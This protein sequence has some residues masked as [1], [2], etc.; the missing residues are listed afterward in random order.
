MYTKSFFKVLVGLTTLFG[1]GMQ[2]FGQ[3][4][5]ELFQ[6]A[7]DLRH[8]GDYARA[9][10]Y[11]QRVKGCGDASYRKDCEKW[12]G[13]CRKRLPSLD[14]SESVVRIPYQGGDRKVGVSANGK[15]GIDGSVM[16]WCAT[17]VGDRE[18]VLQCREPN[19]S[20]REKITTLTVKSGSLFRTL[21]VIQD[22]RPE[23]L[24]VSSQ[25]LSFPADGATEE[26]SVETNARWEVSSVP[27][28]CK[29]ER[30]ST[31]IRIVVEANDRIVERDDRIVIVSPS[32]NVTIKI[33]QGAG[34]EHLTLSH[35]DLQLPPEGD[36][37]YIRVYTDADN[38]YVGD[39]PDWCD[40]RRVGTDS[41]RVHV[42]KNVPNGESRM[43]SIKIRT[44]RQTAGVYLVQAPRMPQDLI[45]PEGKVLGGRNVSFGVTAGYVFPMVGASAGGEYVGSAVNY[46]LCDKSENA[47]YGS[48]TGFTVG[49][50]ADIRL[51]KNIFL[52][53]GINYTYYKYKNTFAQPTTLYVPLMGPTYLSGLARNAYEET[54]KHSLLEIPIIASY[55]FKLNT[56]SHVQ[57]NLGPV[58][59]YGMSAKMKLSGN[60]DS[61]SMLVYNSVTH[62]PIDTDYS[63]WHTAINGELD[64]FGK[65]VDWTETY[66]N[67][68]EGDISFQDKFPASPLKRLNFGVQVGAA[69]EISGL[70]FGLAYTAMLTN[71]ANSGYWDTKRWVIMYEGD[72]V[73]SGYKHRIHSLQVKVA[74]TFRYRNKNK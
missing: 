74:Y 6:R 23:Y 7:N 72:G 16:D 55:R 25:N 39:Y 64:L 20:L 19:N 45:F 73:M 51:Y 50:F 34:D 8:D 4:C 18:L 12:I 38:W 32:R 54:Y 28:W 27:S 67:V 14:L 48:Q 36:T 58:I 9:I 40:V 60:T 43:G 41:L 13:W 3:S 15:W 66:T 33:V 57:V 35:N 71:M 70:S 56:T 17:R 52:T 1:G 10:E 44:D 49:A 22:A 69:Y 5:G 53:A 47:S 30:D 29:V 68:G 11:Y 26:V 37:H 42:G 21:K 63:P 46:S 59:S 65:S 31:R 62:Q 2:A 24:E 61:E